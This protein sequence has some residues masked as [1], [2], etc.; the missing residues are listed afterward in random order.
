MK[1]LFGS[2]PTRYIAAVM[3]FVW[4]MSLG[5][6]VANA[7]LVQQDH[8]R[9]EHLSQGHAGF[10]S[11]AGT[12]DHDAADH[13]KSPEDLACLSFCT[14]E[15]NALIQHHADGVMAQDTVPV[16]GFTG[17]LVPVLDEPCPPAVFGSTTWS[18]PPVTIR[19][20]RLTI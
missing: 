15:Q 12:A 6:G 5:I 3:L 1:S 14:A 9:H 10:A 8:G 7:C 13:D 4:L 16:P 19:F 11:G 18:E 20:S 2:Q 17:L